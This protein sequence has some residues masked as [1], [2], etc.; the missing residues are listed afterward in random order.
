MLKTIVTTALLGLLPALAQAQKKVPLTIS[1]FNEAT[2]IPFTTLPV[3]PLHPGVQAGS[4]WVYKY[5]KHSTWYQ[6]INV[7][8]IFHRKLYQGVYINTELGFDYRFAFGLNAKALLGAGYMHSF[9]NTPQ[10]RFKNGQYVPAPNTGN[11]RVMASLS[12]GLGQRLKKNDRY[13]PEIFVLY[14]GWAEY[15]FSPG[16]IP[17]MTHTNLQLGAK[18]F[19]PSK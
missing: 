13:A 10:Y 5:K 6:T 16:F 4:G 11:S 7:G 19:I 3:N 15:P 9:A 18:F 2:A 1:V 8:Y 14:Q 12:T 17:L